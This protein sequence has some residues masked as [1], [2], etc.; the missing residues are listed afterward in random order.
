M[1]RNT[2]IIRNGELEVELLLPGNY[3]RSRYDHSAMVEQIRL[4]GNTFLGREKIGSGYGLGGVGLAFCLEWADAALYDDTAVADLFPLMGTGLLIRTDTS[5]F[6]FNRDYPVVPF[7]HVVHAGEQELS[8]HTLPHLCRGMAFE[9]ERLFRV[10]GNS[11]LVRCSLKNVGEKQIEGTEFC[12]NFF[13][14]NAL[15]VDSS[16]RLSFPYTILPRVRRGQVFVERDA[17]RLGAFDEA[18]ASTAFWLNGFEGLQS[19]WMKLE[20]EK[21]RT[22]VLVEEDFPLCRIYSWNNRD[23]ICPETFIA[24]SL[25]S[26]EERTWTRKYT[27]YTLSQLS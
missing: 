12:H 21:T 17:L 14:F 19:H 16:Y 6:L 20:H 25:A 24:L 15:P 27:F 1:E 10:D 8:V 26:G 7:E 4:G 3:T 13:Q 23:A 18:T 5:P 22:G 11:L 9:Q 2:A